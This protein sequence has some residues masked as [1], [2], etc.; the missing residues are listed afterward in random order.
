MTHV[1]LLRGINVGGKNKV[2]MS[3]LKRAVERLGHEDVVTYI[4]SGNVVFNASGEGGLAK[5][6]Q[7][8]LEVE[9]GF[10]IGLVVRDLD[11]M[12]T[13]EEAIPD[14][15][16]ND[17]TMRTDVLFLGDDVDKPSIVDQLPVRPGIDTAFYAAGAVVW[18]VDAEN[19]TKSGR[20][21]LIGGRLYRASTVR[22]VNTVRKLVGL[23][24]DVAGR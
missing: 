17:K 2:E 18:Q 16:V 23:M 5:P 24:R 15:W 3:R 14:E 22:N 13:L 9:F 7:R 8:A 1:A 20:T 11:T 10:P 19:L 21:K 6:L 4:N 12:I